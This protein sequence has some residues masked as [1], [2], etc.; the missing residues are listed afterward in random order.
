MNAVLA[1]LETLLAALVLWAVGQS[2]RAE[3]R[4]RKGHPA[5]T[6]TRGFKSMSTLLTVFG[7]LSSF[8]VPPVVFSKLSPVSKSLL[9]LGNTAAVFYLT[10]VNGWCRNEIIRIRNSLREE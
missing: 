3:Y 7:F 4:R 6:V 1:V 5:A 9:Y 10:L 2:I 8:F